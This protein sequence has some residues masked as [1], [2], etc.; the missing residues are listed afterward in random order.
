MHRSTS[1][2]AFEDIRSQLPQ[3]VLD[4]HPGWEILYWRAW[5][6][7]WARYRTAPSHFSAAAQ[8]GPASSTQAD[9]FATLFTRYAWHVLPL[10]A[11]LDASQ[12]AAN[13]VPPPPRRVSTIPV[14]WFEWMRYQLSGDRIRLV[15]AYAPLDTDYRQRMRAPIGAYT[16]Q[17]LAHLALTARS[18]GSMARAI[19]PDSARIATYGEEVERLVEA[20][21]SKQNSVRGDDTDE[22]D[23][24]RE[25][26]TEAVWPLLVTETPQWLEHY[27][28]RLERLQHAGHLNTISS[29][30]LLAYLTVLGLQRAHY[31][32]SAW[33]L[34]KQSLETLVQ[35]HEK[36]GALESPD[37]GL[38][39][40]AS[41]LEAIVGVEIDAA[42]ARITWRLY[43]NTPIGVRNLQMGQRKVSLLATEEKGAGVQAKV[44][45]D[46]EFELE[47]VT[48]TTAYLEIV[49]P[50]ENRYILTV[51]DRTEVNVG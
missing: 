24:Q 39:A 29:S 26:V 42:Q 40:I 10:T 37:V 30:P 38:V 32:D 20:L 1:P 35:A 47:I 9:A 49:S 11:W 8:R 31:F 46:G 23:A 5:Q 12:R 19:T 2:P 18:L 51:L 14:A 45:S 44:V 3:P 27:A 7:A 6:S 34:A 50:G 15:Q 22:E 48:P 43:E 17:E 36:D 28:S 16:P 25:R 33:R 41:L 21:A 13:R 4:N